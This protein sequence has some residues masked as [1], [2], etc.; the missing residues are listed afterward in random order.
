MLWETD[1]P[2]E[3]LRQRFGFGDQDAVA[4][5]LTE[6]L[7]EEW[8]I[9]VRD[10]PRLVISD[11]NAIAWVASDDRDYVVKWSRDRD[12]FPRLDASTRLLRDLAA[13]DLP[14]A[15]PA[16]STAGHVRVELEGPAGRLSIAVLPELPGSW[17]DVTDRD[18]VRAAGACLADLHR[19]L[20]ISDVD[21]ALREGSPRSVRTR[22]EG[23]LSSQRHRA[24]NAA[25]SRLER[26]VEDAPPLEGGPQLVHRDYRAANIL[27]RESTVVGILD[28]DDVTMDHRVN[29]L[30]QA[31]VYLATRFTNW[32]PTEPATQRLLWQA[33]HA[34]S[35]LSASEQVWLEILVLWQGLQAFPNP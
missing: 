18:A 7:A 8:G 30:A 2:G 24:G 20:R 16:A 6:V 31:C 28:F 29:D 13:H 1:E 11:Q 9:T 12:R 25:F 26:L 3:A 21:P 32:G 4:D 19:A 14:V 27:T 22:I 5:W 34:V 17:L 10:C 35:P 33:Y 23:W 15:A